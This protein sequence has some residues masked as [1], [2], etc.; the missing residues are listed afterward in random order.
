[1]GFQRELPRA[2]WSDNEP[3]M[4]GLVPN[5]IVQDERLSAVVGEGAIVQ[6]CI[7]GENGTARPKVVI[8]I[9][10]FNTRW[11]RQ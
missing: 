5:K 6:H 4:V 3:A 10:A 8:A 7:E 2:E 9:C 11:R 1:M